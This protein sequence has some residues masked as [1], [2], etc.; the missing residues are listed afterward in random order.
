[1]RNYGLPIKEQKFKREV[2]PP[3]YYSW[4]NGSESKDAFVATM[5]HK[6]YNGEWWLIKN[7]PVYISGSAWFFYNWWTLQ[8]GDKPFF[9]LHDVELFHVLDWVFRSDNIMGLLLFK[10]R[11]AGTT[12]ATNCFCYQKAIRYKNAHIPYMGDTEERAKENVSKVWIAH[13]KMIDFFKPKIRGSDKDQTG[14]YF[15]LPPNHASRKKLLEGK[16]S[17]T[18]IELKSKIKAV[19]AVLG[20]GDGDR[21]LVFYFDEFAKVWKF[22]PGMQ[23]KKLKPAFVSK[24][25]KGA[26]RGKAL[27]PSTILDN[28]DNPDQLATIVRYMSD[29]WQKSD[30]NNVDEYGRT[31]SGLVR[32][33]RDAIT[34]TDILDEWGFPDKEE[35]IRIYDAQIARMSEISDWMGISSFKRQNPRTIED[36]FSIITH[37]CI[38]FP[39]LLDQ[40]LA[41]LRLGNDF[42]G[43]RM[44]S[45]RKP[46]RGNLV[47]T[48][49]TWAEV[50]FVPDE[51]GKWEIS[52]HPKNPNAK[53]SV[54]NRAAPVNDNVYSLAQDP[55]DTLNAKSVKSQLSKTGMTVFKN[56]D[57]TQETNPLVEFYMEDGVEKV[58]NAHL[59]NTNRF[60]CSYECQNNDPY[61]NFRDAMATAIYY[62]VPIFVEKNK[63]FV[64][65]LI[66]AQ[67][68]NYLASKP[69]DMKPIG[70]KTAEFLRDKGI[71]TTQRDK[72]DYNDVWK[73][74]ASDY[75]PAID[76]INIL[77]NMRRFDGTNHTDCDLVVSGALCLLQ[78]RR[79]MLKPNQNVSSSEGWKTNIFSY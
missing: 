59:M 65:N 63:P 71:A 73:N 39:H 43:D 64:Y 78:A 5:F 29:L 26:F 58:R 55:T 47:F 77:E 66:Y 45:G 30:P 17:T 34:T 72:R 33:I 1:M 20:K 60:V 75:I 40:R 62:S 46:I 31:H 21:P 67:Y 50:K 48:D 23:L 22:D 41:Q 36:V 6:W 7:T 69:I 68:Y 24:V 52:E 13:N 70:K 56:L 2:L 44:P 19:A 38:L 4:A 32:L 27:Y 61:D 16:D 74:Y 9:R 14:L 42:Y 3:Q 28:E 53:K 15:E 37:D 25:R 12:A 49:D 8:E 10:I 76:F 18:T 54:N 51:N 35:A 11:Q 57:K 79:F